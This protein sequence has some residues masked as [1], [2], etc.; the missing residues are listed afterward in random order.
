MTIYRRTVPRI[1]WGTG[2][3]NTLTF[4]TPL[5]EAVTYATPRDGSRIAFSAAGVADAWDLGDDYHLE[6]VLRWIPGT[7][8][9]GLSGWDGATGVSAFLTWARKGNA[10]RWY[11]D[12]AGA[13]YWLAY[14]VEPFEGG[15]ELEPNGSRAVMIKLRSADGLT[16]FTGY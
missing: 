14:L 8:A 12:A 15:P 5:D 9:G 3:A 16:P 6:G 4:D 2:F 7:A 13:T 10:F 11:P 1:L